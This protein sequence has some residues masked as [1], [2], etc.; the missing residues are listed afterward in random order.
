[1]KKMYLVLVAILWLTLTVLLFSMK[2]LLVGYDINALLGANIIL[3]ALSIISYFMIQQK[4]KQERAQAFVNG[5]YAASLMRLMIC[6]GSIFSYAFST[7]AHLH[8][9]SVFAMM[10]FYVIYTLLETLVMSK[11]VKK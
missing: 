3:A 7:R 5:V 4:M 9:P 8:K 2:S 6:L 10:G 1:M 11:I